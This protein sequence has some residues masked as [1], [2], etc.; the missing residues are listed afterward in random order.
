MIEQRKKRIALK[1]MFERMQLG[2]D[3]DQKMGNCMNPEEMPRKADK[4]EADYQNNF[5][6]SNYGHPL[7]NFEV[8]APVLIPK[9]ETFTP[10]N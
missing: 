10:Q 6:P 3:P 2:Q 7:Q 8:P 1:E 5:Q 9:S 4:Y